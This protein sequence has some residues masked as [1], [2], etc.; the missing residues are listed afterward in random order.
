MTDNEVGIKIRVADDNNPVNRVEKMFHDI[1]EIVEHMAAE[2]L[3]NKETK[4]A[5]IH[6]RTFIAVLITN[7]LVNMFI[8]ARKS[9]IDADKTLTMF[10]SLLDEV[11]Q[12][13]TASVSHVVKYEAENGLVA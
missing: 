8:K 7:I 2:I 13:A 11:H 4:A 9:G 12:L 5:E 3:S 6:P 1:T 10:Q